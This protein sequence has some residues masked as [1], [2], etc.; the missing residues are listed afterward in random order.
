MIV[1]SSYGAMSGGEVKTTTLQ[2]ARQPASVIKPRAF[3]D[4]P[5]RL[6]YSSVSPILQ[7][8]RGGHGVD[9]EKGARGFQ[10]RM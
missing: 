9:G 10:I 8:P 5:L 1:T 4:A 6:L 3:I 7:S 2:P